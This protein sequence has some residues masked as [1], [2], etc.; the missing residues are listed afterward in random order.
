MTQAVIVA[1]SPDVMPEFERLQATSAD[2]HVKIGDLEV[3]RDQVARQRAEAKPADRAL[4]DKQWA[5]VQHEFNVA[6]GQLSVVT[7]KINELQHARDMIQAREAQQV[8]TV[9][10]PFSDPFDQAQVRGIAIGGF[11]LLIPIV[12]AFARRI[13]VRSGPRAASFDFDSSPRLQRMEQAIESIAIEVERIGEAQRFT[14]KVLSER[15]PEPIAGRIP[16]AQTAR[17]EPGTITPH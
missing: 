8:L 15:Q 13:W 4:Y 17:R 1:Q 12:L 3:R 16:P 7:A 6:Q 11:I 9:P 5:D 10:P 2:L 14:T